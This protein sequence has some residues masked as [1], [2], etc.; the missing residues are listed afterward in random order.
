[1]GAGLSTRIKDALSPRA[2]HP[3]APNPQD[4]GMDHVPPSNDA[5]KDDNNGDQNDD[6]S[7]F[8]LVP[9][10][11]QPNTGR[12]DTSEN[13]TE[14][15]PGTQRALASEMDVDGVSM[16]LA[17]IGLEM[18]A[19]QFRDNLITGTALLLL[20]DTDLR[21]MG[22]SKVGHRKQL[23]RAIGELRV[24]AGLPL[25]PRAGGS[26]E[27]SSVGPDGTLHRRLA[28]KQQQENELYV[29]GVYKGT[30]R[31]MRVPAQA[32]VVDLAS[33]FEEEFG[34]RGKIFYKDAEGDMIQIDKITDLEYAI[35]D[36]ALRGG[37]V[38]L[39]YAD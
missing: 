15:L 27:V 14:S 4:V 33:R 30:V 5:G 32:N 26:D 2:R 8:R 24:A 10:L 28:A 20:E 35:Q 23:M 3:S 29:K 25:S 7:R 13:A 34:K 31:L 22:V 38:K 39:S 11:M 9:L 37:M 6:S 1:M 21:A 16:W 12:D 19:P 17:S 36:S 18:H